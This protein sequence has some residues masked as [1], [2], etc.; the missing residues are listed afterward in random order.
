MNPGHSH[1]TSPS[2][3]R[4]PEWTARLDTAVE[5]RPLPDG[6]GRVE[7]MAA[8]GRGILLL[9]EDGRLHLWDGRGRVGVEAGRSDVGR[10]DGGGSWDD[11]AGT[12]RLHASADG[13]FAAVVVDHGRHGEVLDLDTGAVTLALRNDGFHSGTVPFSL[14]FAVHAGRHVVLHRTDW[15]RITAGDAET[16]TA[17]T[18]IPTD[19]P[20]MPWVSVFHGALHPSPGGGRVVSDGWHW[21]PYGTV[22]AW[23]L[24]AWLAGLESAWPAA[25]GWAQL[26]GCRAH[27]NRP[28]TWLD[29]NRLAVGGLG[30]TEDLLV[31][32]V[33]VYEFL[34]QDGGHRVAQRFRG[35]GGRLFAVDGLLLSAGETGTEIW[36]PVAGARIGAVPGFRPTHR[37]PGTGELLELHAD[38]G[39][40]RSWR[41][42]AGEV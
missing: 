34:D 10:A 4:A 8:T 11:R 7:D 30:G 1:G 9:G 40:L 17:L 6:T 15:N 25:V 32:G 12:R 28:V 36:D 16:G 26:D 42:R 31:D 2:G 27:W 19:R 33:T 14:A 5:R 24:R 18:A 37:H 23:N 22:V 3:P 29:E 41:P 35:P 13:R 38:S 20:E 39:E 21:H